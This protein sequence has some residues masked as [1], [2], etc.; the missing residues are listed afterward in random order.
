[1]DGPAH[2]FAAARIR[3]LYYVGRATNHL[4][5]VQISMFKLISA[6]FFRR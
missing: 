6:R 1:M 3:V 4:K 5:P 2:D